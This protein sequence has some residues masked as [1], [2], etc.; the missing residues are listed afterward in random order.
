[1][2]QQP[3]EPQRAGI[4]VFGLLYAHVV[5]E[6]AVLQSHGDGVCPQ[7]NDPACMRGDHVQSLGHVQP[8]VIEESVS[9]AADGTHSVGID[10]ENA[11][12]DWVS[13]VGASR[14]TASIPV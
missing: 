8:S 1:M 4:F 14:T 10:G 13:A 6:D 7:R 11:V 5:E 3:F 9:P 2:Q 12:A